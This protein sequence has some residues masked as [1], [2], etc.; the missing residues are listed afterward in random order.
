ME[1]EQTTEA[2]RPV[3]R[4]KTKRETSPVMPTV[5][6]ADLAV[7]WGGGGPDGVED[8]KPGDSKKASGAYLIVVPPE[9]PAEAQ[10]ERGEA[11]T[12]H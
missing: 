8:I 10:E 2:R 3:S 4:T 7:V 11:P 12:E 9:E 6:A 5:D 1:R